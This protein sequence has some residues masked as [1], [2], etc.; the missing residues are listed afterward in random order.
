LSG[1][2]LE[3][4][5]VNVF[6][7]GGA[8]LRKA[9]LSQAWFNASDENS[10]PIPQ[11]NLR[12]AN[13]RGADLSHLDLRKSDLSAANLVGVNLCGTNLT[14]VSLS[15]A[16]LTSANLTNTDLTDANMSGACLYAANL[17]SADLT[18]ADL[19]NADL[20]KAKLRG[21]ELARAVMPD[22]KGK[23]RFARV[24]QWL[25]II[26]PRY[27]NIADVQSETKSELRLY[28]ASEAKSDVIRK[29][30]DRS[31]RARRG[32]PTPAKRRRA[33]NWV[34]AVMAITT[35]LVL[36]ALAASALKDADSEPADRPDENALISPLVLPTA[37]PVI[38]SGS[39]SQPKP[40][41][42]LPTHTPAVVRALPQPTATDSPPTPT[43]VR[44]ITA[45][46]D[47]P[48]PPPAPVW[49]NVPLAKP[50]ARADAVTAMVAPASPDPV[51][52]RKVELLSPGPIHQGEELTVAYNWV[53]SGD[54]GWFEVYVSAASSGSCIEGPLLYSNFLEGEPWVVR[55]NGLPW[56][57][58]ARAEDLQT[59][60]EA[61]SL[62]GQFRICIATWG[63]GERVWEEFS[64][65]WLP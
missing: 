6:D 2:I 16:D 41:L 45:M 60:V 61:P 50:T 48:E 4:A 7:L 3:G 39:G 27:R 46:S 1:A 23:G 26:E 30:G 15:G 5:L 8:D 43:E 29:R 10:S 59:S 20:R 17:R 18:R 56:H 28:R 65:E 21:A 37:V 12:G 22:G 42:F 49:T 36:A 31:R 25:E 57:A 24:F 58:S 33:P 62:P 40:T 54:A 64:F 34:V 51:S 11:I 38:S 32:S 47:T 52:D 44:Q 35:A 9:D 19:F 14:G 63:G 13:L 55:H 53:G